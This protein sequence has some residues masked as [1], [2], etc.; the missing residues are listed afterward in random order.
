MKTVFQRGL[1][2]IM[3][4]LMVFSAVSVSAF[5]VS[6]A[7]SFSY[8]TY[9]QNATKENVH[10]LLDLVDDLLDEADINFEVD[11]LNIVI[12][13]TS[14]DAICTTLDDFRLAITLGKYLLGDL[15]ALDLSDFDKGMSR[16]K[17]G[18]FK[19]FSELLGLA[20]ANTS[21]VEAL[22]SDDGLD[23]GI[24]GT[25]LVKLDVL[26]SESIKIDIS[27]MLKGG[28]ADAIFPDDAAKKAKAEANFDEFLYE[29]VMT[30]LSAEG[31]ILEGISINGD[32]TIDGLL[33]NIFTMVFNK[34]LGKLIAE[35]PVS[36]AE[37]GYEKLDD[38]IKLGNY[39][40]GISFTSAPLIDQIN[41]VLR[42]VFLQIVP[43]Y[44]GWKT[45][46]Y[47]LIGDNMRGLVQYIAKNGLG[48][49]PAGKTDEQLML[50]V[51]K[52][53]IQG[54]DANAYKAVEKAGNLTDLVN[55][56]FIYY[57]Y[58]ENGKTYGP[59]ATYEHVIGD[60]IIEKI[61]DTIPLYDLDGKTPIT[62]NGKK[63]VWE[64]FNSFFNFF[65]VDKNLD[66]FFGWKM[67]RASSYFEKLDI[68]LDYTAN[69]GTA[70][71]NSEAYI[72]GLLD[73]AFRIDLQGFIN[74]TA[75]KAYKFA[76][77]AKVVTFLSN[78][79]NNLIKN[80]AGSKSLNSWSSFNDALSGAKIGNLAKVIIE[81]LSSR[82]EATASLIGI[83]YGAIDNVKESITKE[84]KA[85]TC[86]S[87]GYAPTKVCT[88]DGCK[89][90]NFS[91]SND[92]IPATGHHYKSK[93]E[94][95]AKCTTDGKVGHTCVVCGHYYTTKINKLGHKI[96]S[97]K[98]TKAPNCTDKG[99]RTYYC[100]VCKGAAKTE[101]VAATGHKM[102]SWK[103]TKKATYTSTGTQERKCT[104]A[105][106]KYT[107]KKTVSRLTLSKPTGLKSS[108]VSTSSIKF[109]WKK[110]TGA[111][112]Y[113]L[114]Y[115]TGSGKWKTVKTKKT[116]ATVKKLKTG[117]TY[118]FKVV[119]VAGK[120]KSKDSSTVSGSTKP[121]TV[122]LKDLRSKKKKE[123][124]VEWKKVSG[125]TGYEVQYSTSKKFT[126]KTTK[127][128]TIKKQK[129]VK[130]IIKK[131]KSKKKYYVKVRAYKT[132]NKVKVYGAYSKVK[133]IKCK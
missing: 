51:V 54:A 29:D 105:N 20:N 21:L 73:C 38:V 75:V 94:S 101:A 130:T 55:K 23:L 34:H 61:G 125:V 70:N 27:P 124:V 127:T 63:T 118:K 109:S 71:F 76:G 93:V 46:G 108:A 11:E 37:L 47:T 74:A 28:I 96:G 53:I 114:Y 25:V 43:G 81:T 44:T 86:T 78:T 129:T 33:K 87:D 65:L 17:S 102:G 121:A 24:I 133:S 80:W 98:I 10:Y 30:L 59:G 88:K 100:S 41:N 89:N 39:K 9:A 104:N 112:S 106:C 126:K 83:I 128:V 6:A 5:G 14:V 56:L 3:C 90:K 97:N 62:A 82:S 77:N 113:I 42:Q 45:G 13:L 58:K 19:I 1:S 115:K 22:L 103:T 110:V 111:E 85:P 91:D 12:D 31:E 52:V 64:V 69:D 132:V 120:Y 95:A 36:F 84:G 131:L 117:T 99:I 116:S 119:A 18:D 7:E 122:S 4:L 66:A 35:N 123:I 68:I 57:A 72:K 32:T 50:E 107:E 67:T 92:V 15:K 8:K 79:V 40:G 16:S 2:L 26:E 49:N 48:I 60:Y